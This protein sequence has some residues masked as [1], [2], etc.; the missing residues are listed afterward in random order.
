MD[1]EREGDGNGGYVI[2]GPFPFVVW[3]EGGVCIGFGYGE[4]G[5]YCIRSGFGRIL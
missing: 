1:G 4:M 5:A 2:Y 3:C